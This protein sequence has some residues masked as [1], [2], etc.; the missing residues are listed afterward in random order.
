MIKT[1]IVALDNSSFA[2]KVMSQAVSLAKVFN[3]KLI[4]VSVI[5]H[6]AMTWVGEAGVIVMPE[7]IDAA[8]NSFEK[9]LGDCGRLAEK[10][11][12]SFD[13]VILNGNPASEI[14]S[15]ATQKGADLIVLGHIGKTAAEQ[16]LMGSVAYK[17]T[18]YAKCSVFI[19][20]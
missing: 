5:D 17:V 3:A 8:R 4:G 13:S 14:V 20:R 9:R 15:Y 16:I 2:D 7:L 1:M 6:A 19:V 18:N 11:G 12:V 10:E